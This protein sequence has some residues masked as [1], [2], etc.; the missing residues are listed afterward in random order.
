MT[1]LLLTLLVLLLAATSGA[2]R[3]ALSALGKHRAPRGQLANV[4]T[5]IV[6]MERH[7]AYV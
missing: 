5:Y 2:S 6:L 7:C 3:Y 1:Y 4:Y